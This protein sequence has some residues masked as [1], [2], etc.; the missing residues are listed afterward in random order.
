M[1]NCGVGIARDCIDPCSLASLRSFVENK[2]AV[3]GGE[4]VAFAGAEPVR[5][6][7]LDG[8]RSSPEFIRACQAIYEKGTGKAAP[9]VPFYQVLRCISGKSGDKHAFIFHYDSYV[10]TALLPVIIPSQGKRGDLIMLPNTR[11]IRKTYFRNLIDKVLLD[12]KL[13]QLVLK[14][15]TTAGRW[16]AT[17]V[18]LTPGNVYFFWGCRSIH[19]NEPC[20]PENIRATAIF[21]YVDPHA[22][23]WLRRALRGKSITRY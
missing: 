19:A 17:K 7:F 3:N 13:S 21:H 8:L 5:N 15:L 22:S 16:P 12:N 6:T 9:G 4:Y 20:D 10:V 14:Y 1:N 23:S 11:K 18:C 2:V